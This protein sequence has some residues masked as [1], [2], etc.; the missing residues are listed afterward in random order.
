ML[1]SALC[2]SPCLAGSFLPITPGGPGDQ[3]RGVPLELRDKILAFHRQL[4]APDNFTKPTPPAPAARARPAGLQEW[5]EEDELQRRREEAEVKGELQTDLFRFQ[6]KVS[7]PHSSHFGLKPTNY[8]SKQNFINFLK[9]Q[10]RLREKIRKEWKRFVKWRI[11]KRKRKRLKR[12]INRR[13]N[14]QLRKK[15]GPKSKMKTKEELVAYRKRKRRL[16]RRI[17]SR[18]R[19]K[20]LQRRQ[21]R[22][23]GG[24]EPGGR[25]A[26][27][28]AG[29]RRKGMN[30]QT[31]KL[32][33]LKAGKRRKLRPQ[34]KRRNRGRTSQQP[35]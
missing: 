16:K 28:Q 27:R 3:L 26:G 8:P 21:Q 23:E 10:A 20:R 34:I 29:G 22:G 13:L 9:R 24:G 11:Q 17:R 12:R 1:L 31:N 2:L 33:A 14:T 18:L 7:I 25:L 32:K 6:D 4:E 19:L 30:R 15:F 5:T 35:T